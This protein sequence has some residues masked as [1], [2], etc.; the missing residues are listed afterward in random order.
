MLL[1]VLGVLVGFVAV[2][3]LLSLVVTATCQAIQSVLNLR[4]RVLLSGIADLAR[5][6]LPARPDSASVSRE[7]ARRTLLEPGARARRATIGRIFRGGAAGVRTWISPQDLARRLALPLAAARLLRGGEVAEMPHLD[8]AAEQERQPLTEDRMAQAFRDLEPLL[9]RRFSGLMKWVSLGTGLGV[10][11]LYQVSAPELFARLSRQA[12]LWG[13]GD[14]TSPADGRL[15]ENADRAL[16]ELARRHPERAPLIEQASGTGRTIE[17]L[18]RELRVVLSEEA[19]PQEALVAE[20]RQI[21][22]GGSAAPARGADGVDPDDGSAL[23]VVPWSD[24]WEYYTTIGSVLGVLMTAALLAL[25]APSWFNL[26]RNLASLTD[27]GRPPRRAAS[28]D[29]ARDD[30]RPR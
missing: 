20:Y 8:P 9:A 11:F 10:A 19:V 21:I 15:A 7:L 26:L 22:G 5:E 18:E 27:Q 28:T 29:G 2:M 23:R 12:R 14:I 17:D 3:L 16:R 24:G 13:R 6:H 25:G 30:A 4:G 1:E